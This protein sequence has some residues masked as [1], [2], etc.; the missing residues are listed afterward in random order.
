MNVLKLVRRVFAAFFFISITLL[1]L[2]FTGTIHS[3]LSWTAKIQFIPALFAL[4]FVVVA[5]LLLLTFVLGRV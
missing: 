2:D 4:N 1:F 3:F 5:V